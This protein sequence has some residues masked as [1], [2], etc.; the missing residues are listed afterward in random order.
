MR[1]QSIN[2]GYHIDDDL[3]TEL[4]TV[5][6]LGQLRSVQTTLEALA[7]KL[8]ATKGDGKL[9]LLVDMCQHPTKSMKTFIS[10]KSLTIPQPFIFD[11]RTAS[12]NTVDNCPPDELSAILEWPE[13]L[14]PHES[15][16]E[17]AQG[18]LSENF[19]S[20]S[21]PLPAWEP[22]PGNRSL[23]NVVLTCREDV[24]NDIGTSYYTDEV[25][26]IWWRLS[27]EYG[28][29]TEVYDQQRDRGQNLA[30]L[31]ENQG[32]DVEDSEVDTEDA[33][34][35]YWEDEGEDV[36]SIIENLPMTS[37]KPVPGVS[38][39]FII[40]MCLRNVAKHSIGR[41][42]E[43]L[44]MI[45]DWCVE[46]VD[47]SVEIV[48]NDSNVNLR[49]KDALCPTLHFVSASEEMLD[50]QRVHGLHQHAAHARRPRE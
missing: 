17:W 1:V 2:D 20:A 4:D 33:D 30:S 10:L 49:A 32:S 13:L 28:I 15:V 9:D 26:E 35:K 44:S 34:E 29:E 48:R 46:R 24:S 38:D 12:W 25:N 8:E 6:F 7:I 42:T 40:V 18:F 43:Q 19:Y 27:T 39:R 50:Y 11:G 23:K 14:F 22:I 5:Y 37:D 31:Y 3:Y 47:K 36:E 41:T 16:E 45:F 21:S